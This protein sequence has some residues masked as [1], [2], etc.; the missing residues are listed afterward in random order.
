[1]GAIKNII[2]PPKPKVPEPV[3]V[4]TEAESAADLAAAA[5]EDKQ[6]RAAQAGRASTI[7]TKQISG[8]ENGTGTNLLS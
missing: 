4:P 5:E 2:S 8:T 7:L 3:K 6:R 1:M